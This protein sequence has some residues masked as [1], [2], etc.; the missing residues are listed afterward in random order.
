M[1]EKTS[2]PTD[3]RRRVTAIP[4]RN[5]AGYFVQIDKSILKLNYNDKELYK[6]NRSCG[7]K[8]DDSAIS[9]SN[10]TVEQQ[11]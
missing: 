1:A 2:Y 5:L 3:R 8:L 6:V 11:Q 4:R 9:T 7:I 10:T